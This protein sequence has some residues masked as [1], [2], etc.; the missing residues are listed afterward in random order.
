M[1]ITQTDL[2]GVFVFEPRRFSDDR[3]YFYETWQSQRYKDAGIAFDFVQDNVSRS[4]RGVLRGLHFQNP[5]A[6]G[7]LVSV[8]DGEVFDVAV[9]IR[10]GSPDFG[11][12]FGILLSSENAKQLWVPPGFAHGFYVT[13]ESAIFSYKC[14]DT[15]SPSAEGSLRWDDPAIG[16]TWPEGEKILAPKDREAPLL[17]EIPVNKLIFSALET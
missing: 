17:S 2:P 12:W 3:G 5:Q 10:H 6:Q 9:D 16:I 11:K 4:K 1:T 8:L 7:K 14:T 15:Y 13:S